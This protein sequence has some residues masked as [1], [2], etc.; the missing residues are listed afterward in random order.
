MK[1]KKRYSV[2]ALV[3]VLLF[4]I[5]TAVAKIRELGIAKEISENGN[6][7][8]GDMVTVS[9]FA[10]NAKVKGG[11]V[12]LLDK[13]V[14]EG[15]VSLE[16]AKPIQDL[17]AGQSETDGN[18]DT[19]KYSKT[20]VAYFSR[21][22]N[23]EMV[24]SYIQELTNGNLFEIVPFVPYPADYQ[25][26]LTRA[27][28]ELNEDYRPDL[29]SRIS[30]ID[31]YDIIF[32]GFP[33]WH[34][35]TPMAIRSFLEKY[36]L[37][38]KTIAVFATSGS[39]GISQAMATVRSMCPD[40]I[41][42]DG[43]SI[44][45]VTLANAENLAKDWVNDMGL[46]K[47]KAQ[48]NV[49]YIQV[50]EKTLTATLV[51]NSSTKALKELLETVPLTIDMTDYGNM[52]KVGGLGTSLP[53]NNEQITTEPGDLILYQGNALVIY[54]APNTWNFTWLGKIN[55]IT[56]GEELKEILGN[57]NVQVTLSLKNLSGNLP[58]DLE[59]ITAKNNH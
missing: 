18:A 49:I 4:S 12:T 26:C 3:I 34:G 14:E 24:A 20:L 38:G 19:G 59:N 51:E 9:Y 17:L 30:N 58:L 11:N 16:V 32:L 23:T 8:R 36:N 39:S 35:N 40:S 41:V 28:S 25:Q 13:L 22:G 57:G 46:N 33:I 55:D 1:N 29:S 21:K 2:V 37:S 50:G 43:L 45:S 54:Y 42:T 53:T 47:T 7:K 44:T 56:T 6:F 31:E 48:D 52:E 5:N 15:A 10:L 27:M